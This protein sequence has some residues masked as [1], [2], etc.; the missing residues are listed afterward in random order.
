MIKLRFQLAQPIDKV[1][2]SR[3]VLIGAG[4]EDVAGL[5]LPQE[6]QANHVRITE[7]NREFW[8]VN[9]VNDPF[10]NLNGRPFGKKLLRN[11]DRLT[12]GELDIEFYGEPSF[13]SQEASEI[14]AL[15]ERKMQGRPSQALVGSRTGP[16]TSREI[17]SLLEEVE[18]L[19]ELPPYFPLKTPPSEEA[20][21]PAREQAPEPIK[22]AVRSPVEAP[23][24]RSPPP[25][26]SSGPQTW[27]LLIALG[28]ALFVITTV[29]G[30][31]IYAAFAEQSDQQE[32]FAAKDVADVAMA[33]TY[34]Q[35][36]QVKP[37][38]QNWADPDFIRQ[39]LERVLDGRFEST[40]GLDPQGYLSNSPYLL[41]IYTNNDSSQFLL[42]AQP[43][44]N[45]WRWFTRQRSILFD[46]SSM[47]LRR[48]NDLR[49][50]NRLLSRPNAL[51]G[52]HALEVTRLILEEE[53]IPL[54]ELAKETGHREFS[55]PIELKTVLPGAENFVHNAPRYY[56]FGEP[57]VE[58]F[59]KVTGKNSESFFA[60]EAQLEELASLG[61]LVLYS[62]GSLEVAEKAAYVLKQEY[63]ADKIVVGQLIFNEKNGAW[64]KSLLIE[65]HAPL[66]QAILPLPQVAQAAQ[67]QHP[68]Q[69]AFKK[70]I[71]EYRQALEAITEQM[72]QAIAAEKEAFS[73]DFYF[74]M[75]QLLAHYHRIEEPKRQEMQKAVAQLHRSFVLEGK[76]LPESRFLHYAT[77]AGLE[78]YL[79]KEP[80][81]SPQE[82]EPVATA[83]VALQSPLTPI[84]E[85]ASPT[86]FQSIEEAHSL[87]ELAEA[88]DSVKNQI[89][90]QASNEHEMVEEEKTLRTRVLSQL[91]LFFFS[92][93]SPL[94]DSA[95]HLQDRPLIVH[96]L[97]QAGICDGFQCQ[98]YLSEFELLAE[99][100]AKERRDSLLAPPSSSEESATLQE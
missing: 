36:H 91:E 87:K 68:L 1:F 67:Q 100:Y 57:F 99:K 21:T 47:E 29:L 35:V 60:A 40:V 20:A 71:G 78:P 73:P 75:H 77:E 96:I 6:L 2:F 58:A 37:Q 39:N 80:L 23:P 94:D 32:Y 62:S 19:T 17:Q 55:P 76:S 61:N 72:S 25:I 48:T 79:A 22:A 15:L 88:V 95:F 66:S 89:V 59:A 56:R 52:A 9:Q 82:E 84:K 13:A 42:V 30:L 38:N 65:P 24:T 86:V 14:E 90:T 41:R 92:Q 83:E 81:N 49:A 8:V 64:V 98:F 97:E 44:A 33:L 93:H 4:S 18:A 5:Q 45:L 34:A 50:L 7:S 3:T 69:E 16:E 51:G 11:G 74:K 46:S 54:K 28:T 27:K 85:E 43:S 26:E 63:G 10:V 53:A 12:I 70:T 31:G